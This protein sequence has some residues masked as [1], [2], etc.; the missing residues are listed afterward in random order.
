[1]YFFQAAEEDQTLKSSPTETSKNPNPPARAVR[2]PVRTYVAV[3]L[4]PAFRP[5]N[6]GLTRRGS[7][8]RRRKERRPRRRKRKANLRRR[9]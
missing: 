6:R 2:G 4:Q 5:R 8:G 1:M 9:G 3:T 7:R